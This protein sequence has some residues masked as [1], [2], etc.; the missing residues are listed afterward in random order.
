MAH[1]VLSTDMSELV[2]AMKLVEKY[3]NTTVESGYRK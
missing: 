3:N 1:K 2:N